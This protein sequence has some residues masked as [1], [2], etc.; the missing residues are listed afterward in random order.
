VEGLWQEIDFN[1]PVEIL[2]TGRPSEYTVRARLNKNILTKELPANFPM[3]IKRRP[4]NTVEGLSAKIGSTFI[5]HLEPDGVTVTVELPRPYLLYYLDTLN[6][7]EPQ[8][9]LVP[10]KDKEGPQPCV[11]FPLL[12]RNSNGEIVRRVKNAAGQIEEI[13]MA[14]AEWDILVKIPLPYE[15][16]RQMDRAE[17]AN[18]PYRDQHGIV[19]VPASDGSGGETTT[20]IHEYMDRRQ[21]L[22]DET[23]YERFVPTGDFIKFWLRGTVE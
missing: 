8:A 20:E 5:P 21:K 7:F 1:A 23:T 3:E 10:A 15:A 13:P 14:T 6:D 11:K 2:P 22:L 4:D 16:V 18:W 19:H 17:Y 9:R 12:R